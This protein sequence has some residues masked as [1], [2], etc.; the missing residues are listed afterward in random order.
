MPT[1]P[2]PLQSPDIIPLFGKNV[3]PHALTDEYKSFVSMNLQPNDDNNIYVR[4]IAS[5]KAQTVFTLRAV[6]S[7]LI[8]WPQVWTDSPMLA[9]GPIIVESSKANEVIASTAPF[10]FRPSNLGGFNHTLIT[11]QSHFDKP[12]SNIRVRDTLPPLPKA[13]GNWRD[14]YD[15]ITTDKTLS[16]YNVV[17]ADPTAAIMS[18]TTRLRIFEDDEDTKTVNL[19]IA[20]EHAGIP[21]ETEVSVSSDGGTITLGRTKVGK[22][23][24]DVGINVSLPSDFDGVITLNIFPP[25]G[26][27]LDAYSWVSLQ[28]T[29]LRDGGDG[30]ST[31]C[32]LGALNVVFEADATRNARFASPAAIQLKDTKIHKGFVGD[33]DGPQPVTGWWFRDTLSD[34]NAYPRVGIMSHSPD[35]QEVGIAP[36]ANVAED[37]GGA[38]KGVDYS[39][40][41]NKNLVSDAPNYVYLRGNCT[42]K[43]WTVQSRLF[44]VPNNVLLEPSTYSSSWS[45]MDYDDKHQNPYVA[46]R[47]ITSPSASS[48]NIFD[49]AFMI[50]NPKKPSVWGADHYCLVAETRVPTVHTPDPHW[51]HEDTGNFAT[52]D[53][54]NTWVASIPTVAW[55]NVYSV[56]G[57]TAADLTIMSRMTVTKKFSPSQ[58][59]LLTVNGENVPKDSYW[60]LTTNGP[61]VKGLDISFEKSLCAAENGQPTHGCNFTGLPKDG[62]DAQLVLQW[63]SNGQPRKNGMKF[64]FSLIASKGPLAAS[65]HVGGKLPEGSEHWPFSVGEHYPGLASHP[66]STPYRQLVPLIEK[67]GIQPHPRLEII[68]KRK[69]RKE[70][71]GAEVGVKLVKVGVEPDESAFIIGG[72]N[73]SIV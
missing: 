47:S 72:D 13:I 2:Y 49:N 6:P 40:K 63:W 16:Y 31:A 60:A 48:F 69:L 5:E 35:I 32:L 36:D 51:P 8:L 45:C 41:N 65:Q 19:R 52:G 55:R 46:V 54:F 58:Y 28:A 59:W 24:E 57:G 15:F 25:S 18:I 68:K 9:P 64:S 61:S 10:V 27:I 66:G 70:R 7:E 71:H 33:G 67:V 20:I 22:S 3:S 38:N 11:V 37:M 1:R 73:I 44:C 50:L 12:P 26:E 62:Y 30:I 43:D 14:Y 21:P 42:E 17:V 4:G 56:D 53:D 39:D 29:A 23:S 34:T